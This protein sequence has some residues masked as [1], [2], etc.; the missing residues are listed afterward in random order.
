MWLTNLADFGIPLAAG[1]YC[2]ALGGDRLGGWA[3]HIP[4]L[5]R[6]L[7]SILGIALVVVT[8]LRMAMAV[9]LAY[10]AA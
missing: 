10:A 4:P 9:Y 7:L 6:K 5:N 2:A 3:K 8:I 1:L